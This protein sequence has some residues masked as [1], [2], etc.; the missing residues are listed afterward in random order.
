VLSLL[1]LAVVLAASLSYLFEH[2]VQPD[3]FPHI[4]AA[5]YWA[6]ITL[7]TVGYG[8]MVPL[9][10]MGKVLGAVIAI[11]GV[12]MVALPAGIL[13]SAFSEKLSRS[14]KHYEAE[15]SHALED[16]LITNEEKSQLDIL[17]DDLGLS[18]ADAEATLRAVVARRTHVD[19]IYMQ[20][21]GVKAQG[22]AQDTDVL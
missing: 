21:T 18:E 14:R 7:T 22:K 9:T 20:T 3:V 4:P 5:M 2:P 11:I 16:G 8:D 17:R 10:P 6:V 12:G 13:S 1:A 19:G 15:V